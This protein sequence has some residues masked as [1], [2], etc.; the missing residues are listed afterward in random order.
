MVDHASDVIPLLLWMIVAVGGALFSL[1]IW[2]GQRL[3]NYIEKIPTMIAEKVK[4][5]HEDLL[6]QMRELGATQRKLEEDVR[7]KTTDL[8]RRMVKLEVRCE[9]HTERKNHDAS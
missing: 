8:D 6:Y 9:L 4:Q 5:V 3:Y 2:L 7:S 1:I